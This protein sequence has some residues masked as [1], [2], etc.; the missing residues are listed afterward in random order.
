MATN[1]ALDDT[2]GWSTALRR[3]KAPENNY[4]EE[5]IKIVGTQLIGPVR[6]EI[7]SGIKTRKQ[8]D[9]LRK[10]VRAFKDLDI[11]TTH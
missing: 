5:L 1:L 9:I 2:S 8:F 6:Q 3:S 4:V 10:H 7:L 11:E